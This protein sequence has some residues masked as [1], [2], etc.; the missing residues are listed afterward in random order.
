M[1]PEVLANLPSESDEA[2][3]SRASAPP[4]APNLERSSGRFERA[5]LHIQVLYAGA[6]IPNT[7]WAGL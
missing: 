1:L 2:T 5:R 4:S 3:I 6:K 7:L